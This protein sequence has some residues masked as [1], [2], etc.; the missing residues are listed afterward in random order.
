MAYTHLEVLAVDEQQ[1]DALVLGLALA[2]R[3]RDGAAGLGHVEVLRRV[4]R[5]LHPTLVLVTPEDEVE[6]VIEELLRDV[7]GR[8]VLRSVLRRHSP[9]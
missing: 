1:S 6:E 3:G 4:E 8:A 5:R 7:V 2:E 9:P